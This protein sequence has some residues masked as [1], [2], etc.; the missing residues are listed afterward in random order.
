MADVPQMDGRASLMDAIR[1]AGGKMKLRSAAERKKESKKK[2]QE[3][4]TK[5]G[6]DLMSD[7]AEQLRMRRK[8]ISGG[9]ARGGSH[10]AKGSKN[11]LDKISDIIPPPPSDSGSAGQHSSDFKDKDWE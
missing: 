10:S 3:E 6:G 1:N 11:I 2:K 9:D 7:L 5:G 8:G 4:S